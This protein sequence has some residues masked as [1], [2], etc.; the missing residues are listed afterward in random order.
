MRVVLDTNVIVSAVLSIRGTPA[1]IIQQWGLGAFELVVSDWLLAEYRHA[2]AYPHIRVRY[3]VTEEEV[4]DLL[5]T[6]DKARMKPDITEH[7]NII[8]RDPSDNNVL[9]CAIAGEADFIVTG[10]AHLLELEKYRDIEIVSPA[11]FMAII[12]LRVVEGQG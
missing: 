3:S 2:L 9:E 5:D 7:V 8:E 6:L 12:E 11:V 10:D 1:R 4:T